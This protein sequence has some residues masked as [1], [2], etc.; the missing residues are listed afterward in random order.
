VIGG[1]LQLPDLRGQAGLDARS[2]LHIGSRLF[3]ALQ[4]SYRGRVGFSAN[5]MR[6]DN[7]KSYR[8]YDPASGTYTGYDGQRRVCR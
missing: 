4:H 7:C 2:E 5:A 1:I 8:T 6:S 3:I